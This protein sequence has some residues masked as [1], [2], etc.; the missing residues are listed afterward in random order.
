M[1]QQHI[2]LPGKN[3]CL[4]LTAQHFQAE[5][6]FQATLGEVRNVLLAA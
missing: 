1:K 5:K 2:F 6:V 4:T 3:T